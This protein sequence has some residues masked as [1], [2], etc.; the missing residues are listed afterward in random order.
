MERCQNTLQ[1]EDIAKIDV[2]P[3]RPVFIVNSRTLSRNKEM[4]FK[5]ESIEE[6]NR[7]VYTLQVEMRRIENDRKMRWRGVRIK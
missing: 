1:V 2:L 7:W 5:C 3:D 4:R 6:S